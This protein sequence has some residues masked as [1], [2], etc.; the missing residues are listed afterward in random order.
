MNQIDI[1]IDIDICESICTWV[2]LYDCLR[3]P[4]RT[5]RAT[6]NPSSWLGGHEMALIVVVSWS[7]PPHD[8]QLNFRSAQGAFSIVRRHSRVCSRLSNGFGTLVFL[9]EPR[10]AVAPCRR[11]IS[12]TSRN[13]RPGR[14]ALPLADGSS[15][16]TRLGQTDQ[17][18]SYCMGGALHNA[19]STLHFPLLS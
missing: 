14:S 8:H 16:P 6:L 1:D 5:G 15:T 4:N 13:L 12:T 3:G 17:Y 19:R 9:L 7:E 11:V 2:L 18:S 10:S